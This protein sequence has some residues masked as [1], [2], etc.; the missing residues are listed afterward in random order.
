[1]INKK[2]KKTPDVLTQDL[3]VDKVDFFLKKNYKK[4]II[5]TAV[6]LLVVMMSFTFKSYQKSKLSNMLNHI[7]TLES[8]A[9]TSA[10]KEAALKKFSELAVLYP[11]MAG[12]I[13]YTAGLIAYQNNKNELAVSYFSK[14]TGDFKEISD[15]M[16]ADISDAKPSAATY[17]TNGKM[18]ELWFYREVLSAEGEQKAKLLEEFKTAYPDSGLVEILQNWES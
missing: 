2:K 10:D 13:N 7:G 3:P 14:T 6:I 15:S 1:M 12:Y 4:I 17:R 8:D 5:V 11:E 18:K 16:L 9:M